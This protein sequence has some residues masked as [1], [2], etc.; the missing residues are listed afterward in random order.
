MIN[1]RNGSRK[2]ESYSLRVH[3]CYYWLFI[4]LIF[5]KESVSTEIQNMALTTKANEAT[6]TE[7][8]NDKSEVKLLPGGKIK[9]KV[10]R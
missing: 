1:A 4:K 7:P 5:V 9:K 8:Q 3:S 2:M 6:A 10:S